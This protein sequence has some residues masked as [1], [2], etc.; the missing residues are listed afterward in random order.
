MTEPAS[1]AAILRWSI[2]AGFAL[3]LG[4]GT[5]GF[6]V[7]HRRQIDLISSIE[8]LGASVRTEQSRPE[9]LR[10]PLLDQLARGSEQIVR[11]QYSK[12]GA[13]RAEIECLLDLLQEL[14]HLRSLR[15]KFVPLTDEDTETI[16]TLPSLEALDFDGASIRD[17]GLKPLATLPRLDYLVL[18]NTSVGDTGLVHLRAATRLEMVSLEN[19]AVSD[20]GLGHL[21]ALPRLERVY[22]TGT[23]VTEEGI[24]QLRRARPGLKIMR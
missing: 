6:A 9:W 23:A 10:D 17:A 18:D 14:P 15:M 4:L 2:V 1:R 5:L 3:L 19:T 16:A 24:E 11:V 7:S 22:L 12:S 13:T 8:Q 21:A 20:A